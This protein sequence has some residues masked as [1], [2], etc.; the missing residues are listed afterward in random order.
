MEYLEKGLQ[1]IV[2]EIRT[3]GKDDKGTIFIDPFK[4]EVRKTSWNE[5]R[6]TDFIN[7]LSHAN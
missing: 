1:K 4:L 6:V 3:V 5:E 2:K 7:F